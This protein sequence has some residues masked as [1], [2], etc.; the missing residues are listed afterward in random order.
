MESAN[1]LGVVGWRRGGKL[2]PPAEPYHYQTTNVTND[3]APAPPRSWQFVPPL[4]LVVW[5]TAPQRRA[6]SNLPPVELSAQ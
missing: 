1:A 4:H 6:A 2:R 5:I 3:A